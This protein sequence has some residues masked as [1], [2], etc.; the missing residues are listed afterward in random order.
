MLV[1]PM[2]LARQASALLLWPATCSRGLFAQQLPSSPD[3]F[4]RRGV[5]L[6]YVL[7]EPLFDNEQTTEP[8]KALYATAWA[9]AS[10]TLPQRA[11]L[12]ASTGSNAIA[13]DLKDGRAC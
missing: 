2:K 6:R 9:F 5:E 3:K 4:Q 12:A 8:I 7:P 13:V 1:T 11:P 10:S